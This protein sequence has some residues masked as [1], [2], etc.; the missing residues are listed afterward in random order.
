MKNE[1][2]II[3]TDNRL[4]CFKKIDAFNKEAVPFK[5]DIWQCCGALMFLFSQRKRL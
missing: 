4:L 2:K 5:N 3:S 1:K